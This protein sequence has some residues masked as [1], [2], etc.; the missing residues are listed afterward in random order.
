MSLLLIWLIFAFL[1]HGRAYADFTAMT[2]RHA[3]FLSKDELRKSL[4]QDRG[5][6]MIV[7]VCGPAGLLVTYLVGD[8]RQNGYRWRMPN[9]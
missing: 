8:Y 1:A 3:Y 5:L 4:N 7:A 9:V 6:A 2:L